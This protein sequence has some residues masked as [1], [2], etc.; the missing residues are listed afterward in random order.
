[1]NKK[2]EGHKKSQ[3]CQEQPGSKICFFEV[4]INCPENNCKQPQGD[5]NFILKVKE[6]IFG[7]CCKIVGG[8]VSLRLASGKPVKKP[9][10]QA[11][12]KKRDNI[13]R[14]KAPLPLIGK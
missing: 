11:K 5:K 1:M 14:E 10:N 8:G 9:G 13:I 4:S 6:K 2:S 7:K 12:A 3:R